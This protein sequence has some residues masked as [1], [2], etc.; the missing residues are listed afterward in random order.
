MTVCVF[1]VNE[2]LLD[3]AALDPVFERIFGRP[4]RRG[5]WFGHL[6]ELFLTATVIGEHR[7]FGDHAMAA[8]ALLAEIEGVGL[9]DEGRAAVRDGMAS[10]P[11]HPDVRPAL[12]RLRDGGVRLAALTQS[13]QP[14]LDAQLRAAGLAGLLDPALSADDVGRLKPAREAYAYAAQRLGVGLGDLTLVAAHAWDI[15]GARAAGARTAFVARPG[16]ALDPLAPPPDLVV[17]DLGELADE[18]LACPDHDIC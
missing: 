3:L 13:A 12:E 9:G 7:P 18:L 16:K 5:R 2:T 8:L 15:A 11:P 4:G 10:L 17:A 6:Q 1:D 14:V